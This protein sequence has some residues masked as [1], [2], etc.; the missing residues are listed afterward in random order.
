MK[1]NF[2]Y[3]RW[4]IFI[5]LFVGF[6]YASNLHQ[7]DI[8]TSEMVVLRISFDNEIALVPLEQLHSAQIINVCL[9]LVSI[10]REYTDLISQ[11]VIAF[12]VVSGFFNLLKYAGYK[13]RIVPGPSTSNSLLSCIP[14]IKVDKIDF[15]RAML[16]ARFEQW[17]FSPLTWIIQIILMLP[18]EQYD[19]IRAQL[20]LPDE[21]LLRGLFILLVLTIYG[22]AR[23]QS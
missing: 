19:V 9:V 21:N 6:C 20:F 18:T 7:R 23:S 10:F 4:I 3:Q 5:F 2:H 17:L 13:L 14:K 22:G 15:S 1:I 16:F 12:S 8:E 11:T